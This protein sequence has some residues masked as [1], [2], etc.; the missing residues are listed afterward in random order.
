M[1]CLSFSVKSEK[2]STIVAY[3]CTSKMVSWSFC[4]IVNLKSKVGCSRRQ[5]ADA[6][7]TNGTENQ[8]LDPSASMEITDEYLLDSRKCSIVHNNRE[9]L[10]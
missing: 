8:H 1:I 9:R 5:F 2:N 6:A 3:R 10:V 4:R 7:V